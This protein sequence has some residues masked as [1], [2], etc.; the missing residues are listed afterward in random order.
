M[1]P[2]ENKKMLEW[3]HG[4][5]NTMHSKYFANGTVFSHIWKNSPLS[6]GLIAAALDQRRTASAFSWHLTKHKWQI[7]KQG[8]KVFILH[9]TSAQLC[10]TTISPSLFY[11]SAL[12][13]PHPPSTF[14]CPVT[15][16]SIQI[17]SKLIKQNDPFLSVQC[18]T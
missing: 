9:S 7:L 18:I 3:S 17:L 11:T 1:H 12:C 2:Y 15:H 16:V 8:G 13:P 14:H 4:K 6:T 10:I 5:L